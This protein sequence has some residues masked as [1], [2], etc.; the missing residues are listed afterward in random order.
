MGRGGELQK[1]GVEG[2]FFTG[3]HDLLCPYL[4]NLFCATPSSAFR[5]DAPTS[6]MVKN[7]DYD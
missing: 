3:W 1:G 4:P 2:N 5:R 7:R 6:T